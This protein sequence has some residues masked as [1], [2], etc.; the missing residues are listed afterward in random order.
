[1]PKELLQIMGINGGYNHPFC[2]KLKQ[3]KNLNCQTPPAGPPN[4]ALPSKREILRG[5]KIFEGVESKKN[6]T[7]KKKQNV[8][9]RFLL[10]IHHP[11]NLWLSGRC[12]LNEK[13]WT[14]LGTKYFGCESL[15]MSPR[16]VNQG[17]AH[18]PPISQGIFRV[19]AKTIVLFFP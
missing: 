19:S 10:F 2:L 13:W 9:S 1:M 5:K 17:W 11:H 14:R 8:Q 3:L 6:Q 16:T 12:H 18:L 7:T 15:D 4:T